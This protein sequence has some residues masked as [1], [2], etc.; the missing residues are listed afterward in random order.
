MPGGAFQCNVQIVLFFSD[1]YEFSLFVF[2]LY[3][4][5][6]DFLENF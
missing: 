5:F 1:F 2:F 3:D 4:F 6:L